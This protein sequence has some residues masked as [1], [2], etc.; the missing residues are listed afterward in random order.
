MTAPITSASR[1]CSLPRRIARP[2]VCRRTVSTRPASF[3]RSAAIE[4]ATESSYDPNTP[5]LMST[6]ASSIRLTAS[7]SLPRI[8]SASFTHTSTSGVG[9]CFFPCG[10][11]QSVR[12]GA[13]KAASTSHSRSSHENDLLHGLPPAFAC[14]LS[15]A[16]SDRSECRHAH[17][18]VFGGSAE[19][20]SRLISD[21]GVKT[22]SK[23]LRAVPYERK[24]G[25][26]RKASEAE[27]K[28]VE[29]GD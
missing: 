19:S 26:S 27:L 16:S 20:A 22:T 28:G 8:L 13:K 6:A 4:A 25:W 24:S 23:R 2:A 14:A 17:D 21:A 12:S 1:H 11:T 10:G 3:I 15:S 18:V 9:F 5:A 29:G 7:A